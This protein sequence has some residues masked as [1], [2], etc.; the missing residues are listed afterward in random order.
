M[1]KMINYN[2]GVKQVQTID[3]AAFVKALTETF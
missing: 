3:E 2:A 1:I